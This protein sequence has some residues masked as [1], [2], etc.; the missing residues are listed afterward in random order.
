MDSYFP[1]IEEL[2]QFQATH[3]IY[4]LGVLE[5]LANNLLKLEEI[6]VGITDN[7]EEVDEDDEEGFQISQFNEVSFSDSEHE[8]LLVEIIVKPFDTNY[9]LS[10]TNLAGEYES[11]FHFRFNL[12]QYKVF[13]QYPKFKLFLEKLSE[14]NSEENRIIDL[15]SIRFNVSK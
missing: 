2:E 9:T 6:E 13:Y 11:S 12:K 3:E 8:D 14:M 4:A 7:I 5:T 1:I 15:K 10:I